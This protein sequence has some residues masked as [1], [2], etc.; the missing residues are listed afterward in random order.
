MIKIC[1]G[2]RDTAWSAT[3]I[4]KWLL[5]TPK[6]KPEELDSLIDY[7]S[8][9]G[10]QK[11]AKEFNFLHWPFKPSKSSSS[12]TPSAG[13]AQF[14]SESYTL[15][16]VEATLP[17]LQSRLLR[18]YICK[19]IHIKVKGGKRLGNDELY[20]YLPL[21]PFVDLMYDVVCESGNAEVV[22]VRGEFTRRAH[23]TWLAMKADR[24]AA[25]ISNKPV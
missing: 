2:R 4:N 12:S 19:S 17:G 13:P 20:G 11:Q 25:G 9:H 7:Q 24:P 6:R 1:A 22:L 3:S 21:Q 18:E 10:D 8:P 14:R 5:E 15:K 23:K 16:V